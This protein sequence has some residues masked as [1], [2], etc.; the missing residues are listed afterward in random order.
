MA[1]KRHDECP[2][3]SDLARF[4][5]GEGTTAERNRL[6]RHLA[7]CLACRFRAARIVA[8]RRP[9]HDTPGRTSGE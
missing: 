2:A 3:L 5:S 7:R 6:V 8:A 4:C 9:A 1:A